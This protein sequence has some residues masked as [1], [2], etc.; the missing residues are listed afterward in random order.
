MSRQ[1][2]GGWLSLKMGGTIEAGKHAPSEF[3]AEAAWPLPALDF[4]GMTSALQ[5]RKRTTLY[6]FQLLHLSQRSL[7]ATG[8]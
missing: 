3:P 8:N 1:A 6:Y 5:S 2:G 4:T 7:E